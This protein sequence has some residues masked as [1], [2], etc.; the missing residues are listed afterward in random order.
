[1]PE[2]ETRKRIACDRTLW[3]IDRIIDGSNPQKQVLDYFP[4][5]DLFTPLTRR[6][7]LPLG[8]LTS[9]FFGNY[10]LNPLDHYIKEKLKC[11]A[12][13]RYVDD[14]ALFENSKSRLW[15]W[16]KDIS[17]FLQTFRLKLQPLRCQVYPAEE[18]YRFLGQV[19]FRSRRRLPSKNVRQFKKRQKEWQ[20]N[21]PAN[22][23]QRLAA[24]IGHAS[25]ADTFSLLRSLGLGNYLKK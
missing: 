18:G 16:K 25:Q 10:Y 5:D 21:P 11:K 6:R 19:V 23:Q 2:R 24:W 12:Y 9:Q 1:M 14:F 22:L 8:N 13:L 3:L 4:G 7:G 20:N 15:Q 17:S